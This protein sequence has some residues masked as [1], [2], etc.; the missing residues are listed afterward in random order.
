MTSCLVRK[1]FFAL[2]PCGARAVAACSNCGRPVCR[3]HLTADSRCVECGV[4]SH[5]HDEE[6]DWDEGQVYGYRDEYWEEESYDPAGAADFD[7]VDV[8]AFAAASDGEF[9]FGGDDEGGL[10]DS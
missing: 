10:F 9:D 3:R 5:D 7:T 1:G 4:D 8:A 6:G 2:R